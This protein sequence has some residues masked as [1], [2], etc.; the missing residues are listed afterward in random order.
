[1]TNPTVFVNNNG[2]PYVFYHDGGEIE[3]GWW[4]HTKNGGV[5][6][7]ATEDAAIAALQ[8]LNEQAETNV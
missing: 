2:E 3:K 1:M 5:G 7:Y 8:N 6:P 4:I